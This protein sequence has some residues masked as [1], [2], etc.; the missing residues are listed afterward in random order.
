M[1]SNTTGNSNTATGQSALNANTT[2]GSNTASG[3]SALLNNTTG[4]AN[5]ASG[6]S[7]LIYNTT[8][9][10]NTAVGGDALQDNTTGSY[11]VASGFGALFKNTTGSN[12]IALGWNAGGNISGGNSYNIHIGS[13]GASGDN[14]TIRIGTPGTQTSTYIA[15]IYGGSPETPNLYVCVDANGTLGTTGCSTPSSRRFKEQIADMGDRSDMLLQL[16]PV[17]FF[18]KPQYDDSSHTLQYGLIAEEVAKVYPDMV[19]YDKE[20]QPSSVKYQSLAPMLLNELQKQ[21]REFKSQEL[22]IRKQAEALQLQQEQN[23]KLDDRL[24]ALEVLLSGQTS[25]VARPASGQVAPY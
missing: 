19:G 2:G 14:A 17:T 15:G 13:Q 18:Y 16:R 4:T 8:G 11:N 23:R 6:S 3:Y 21:N 22:Q 5:T 24:T 1:Y 7:A 12:N 9:S 25:K 20:G 10:I